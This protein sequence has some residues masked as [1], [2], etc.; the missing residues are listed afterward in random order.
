MG[1]RE[2]CNLCKT[3]PFNVRHTCSKCGFAICNDCKLDLPTNENLEQDRICS[4]NENN[5]NVLELTVMKP[6]TVLDR[7][8][9]KKTKIRDYT[10]MVKESNANGIKLCF[11]LIS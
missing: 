10:T 1:I 8:R 2:S 5:E 11:I 9:A 6:L 4:N 7:L 3:G